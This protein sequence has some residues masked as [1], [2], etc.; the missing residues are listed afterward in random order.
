[1]SSL[2]GGRGEFL[3]KIFLIIEVLKKHTIKCTAFKCS[4][5]IKPKFVYLV[6]SE[7]KQTEMSE[8]AA[9]NGLL[10]RP[11]RE[12]RWLM[13]KRLKLSSRFQGRFYKE[14]LGGG[15]QSV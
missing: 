9:E 2:V 14:N 5:V 11:S 4:F 13:L 12:N 7:A 8:F 6:H 15:L 10:Q 3:L 1:M